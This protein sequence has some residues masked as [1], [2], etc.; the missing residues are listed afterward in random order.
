MDP[1]AVAGLARPGRIRCA[2]A[3]G[4]P[5]TWPSTWSTSSAGDRAR[6]LLESS[7]AQFQAD[8]AVVG[9]STPGAAQRGGGWRATR[10]MTCH[11]GD[12][13]E[14]SA[15]AP[16]PART[17]RRELAR[18][19]RLR[20]GGPPR[21]AALEKLKP[22]DVIQVPT[23]KYAGLALVLDPASAASPSPVHGRRHRRSVGRPD[24]DHR[25]HH[26]GR[27]ARP[28][29][30]TQ[31]L[32]SALTGRT[33]RPRRCCGPRTC[34]VTSAV[35]RGPAARPPTTTSLSACGTTCANTRVTPV[36]T[37]RITRGGR[38]AATG[39]RRTP[40]SCGRRSRRGPVRSRGCS[41]RSA[42][43][44]VSAATWTRPG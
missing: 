21:P 25:L 6:E 15:A 28:R 24:L 20:S 34:R 43:C 31:A 14:Y 4:P 38:S 36:R 40:S 29:T 10:S 19:G 18:H 11:L 12:F 26:A 17:G 44:C 3:S 7:F 35:R 16:R 13:E 2:R 30:R 5:T 33:P 41:I 9:I 22:G 32:Q 1:R 39:S 42:R 23:G 27:G 37:G 8:R